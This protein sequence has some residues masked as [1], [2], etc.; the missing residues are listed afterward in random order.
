MNFRQLSIPDILLIEPKVFTDPR[1]YFMETY[2]ESVFAEHGINHQFVQD[3]MSSSTRGTLR[4]LHY[5]LDPH[6]QGKLVRVLKGVVFDVAVDI[7]KGSPWFGQWVGV[8]LSADNKL[9]MWIPPGFAHGFCVISETAEFAYKVTDIYAPQAERGII[10][11][12]KDIGVEWP[13]TKDELILSPK[14]EQNPSLKAA[15]F[16]FI[17][18]G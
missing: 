4:G 7:R 1:G 11:N 5:Q 14:D 2:K 17:Y 9:S 13:L 10:W 15:E 3:N 18:E 16:N 12:D 6:A 8:E